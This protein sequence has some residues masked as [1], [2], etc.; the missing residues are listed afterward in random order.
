MSHVASVKLEIKDIDALEASCKEFPGVTFHRGKK[1][2]RWFL[3]WMND[4]SGQDAAYK[5]GIR[6][7]QYGHGEHCISVEGSD[8]DIGVVKVDGGYRLVYDFYGTGQKLA[9]K[10][11]GQALP[12]LKDMYGACVM[13]RHYLKARP[14]QQVPTVVK[15]RLP[16]GAIQVVVTK[17]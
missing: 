13:E 14:G 10:F 6:P 5:N 1:T 12:Q 7:E 11:G 8:Y 16:N 4:Y 15:Q 3:R 2:W 17:R 9:E